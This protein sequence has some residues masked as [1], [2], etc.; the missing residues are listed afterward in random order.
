MNA[1]DDTSPLLEHLFRHQA[2]RITAR[3]VRLLGPANFALAEEAFGQYEAA[4]VEWRAFIKS[5]AHP[6][7]QPRAKQHLTALQGKRNK[8]WRQPEPPDGLRIEPPVGIP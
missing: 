4:A 8:P 1:L 2:G 7:Y 6:Q 3:L 5:G